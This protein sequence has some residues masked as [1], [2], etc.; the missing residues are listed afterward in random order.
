MPELQRT[1]NKVDKQILNICNEKG[2]FNFSDYEKEFF[3]KYTPSRELSKW[4]KC[5]KLKICENCNIS[6]TDINALPGQLKSKVLERIKKLE[7]LS[8]IIENDEGYA[9][10]EVFIQHTKT[11]AKINTAREMRFKRSTIDRMERQSLIVKTDNNSYVVSALG[12]KLTAKHTKPKT[13]A[14]MPNV[15]PVFE[16]NRKDNFKITAFD[17]KNIYE[18]SVNNHISND[19]IKALPPSV[20]KR[21]ETLVTAG[22]LIKDNSGFILTKE[23]DERVQVRK[24]INIEHEKSHRRRNSL[25]HL[26]TEQ[27][28]T[29]SDLAVFLNLSQNQIQKFI[30]NGNANL[31]QSDI[32]YFLRKGIIAR[33]SNKYY[34]V[35]VLTKEGEKLAKELTGD[36]KVFKSKLFSR[37]EEL[38]HDVLI[39]NAYQD[40]KKEL[41]EKGMKI[42]SVLNDRAMRS[43]DAK[44]E[45][46]MTG[47]YADL[48][49]EF[50]NPLTGE[51]DYI[52]I[53]IDCGYNE[54]TVEK[55]LSGIKNL[56]YYCDSA[57]Q[58][59][60][61]MKVL[62]SISRL[63]SKSGG[64]KGLTKARYDKEILVKVIDDDEI[65]V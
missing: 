16:G 2:C 32:K 51:R 23:F 47:E 19:V 26:T 10:T 58:K 62:N 48:Y 12:K 57:K 3:G 52:N 11:K 46:Q 35:F 36:D 60:K 5:S 1:I 4:L 24:Q 25:A 39:Y 28:T 37:R 21:I 54:L 45:G 22:L 53:E 55:K 49:I 6:K 33:G 40:V 65:F 27:K 61:V 7:A 18:K 30:Y 41:E 44:A 63:S 13:D 31:C 42:I 38:K 56:R 20:T 8:Y 15:K 17:I 43:R 50:E 59:N 29:L 9:V 14:F 34:N 64:H